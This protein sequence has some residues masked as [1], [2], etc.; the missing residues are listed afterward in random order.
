MTEAIQRYI[1]DGTDDDLRRL[2]GISQ[3]AEG[4]AR[5][6]LDRTGIRPGWIAI[7]CGC[8]PIGGLAVL[9]DL[10]GPGGRVVGVDLNPAA[11]EQARNVA[12]TL[13]LDNVEV[14]AGDINA[15]DPAALGGPFDVAYTRLFLTHQPDSVRTLRRIAGLLRPGGWLVAHEPLPTPPPMSYPGLTALADYW[16][17]LYQLIQRSGVP[18]GTVEDL[19]RSAR[20]AG[21]EVIGLG[22]SFMT[23]E[24]ELGFE[25]HAATIAAARER[26]VRSGLAT[27]QRID[28]LVGAL[29]GAKDGDYGWVTSP[30]FLELTL[31]KPSTD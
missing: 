11:V 5:S 15:M 14:F 31:R 6:A 1:L 7:D 16:A 18:A 30:F 12:S 9:A 19:P 4:M 13:G 23:H 24:P 22:G 17:L 28:E 27:E 21:F 29:R 26:A 8:G 10:V 25:L 20:A 2:L 3:A